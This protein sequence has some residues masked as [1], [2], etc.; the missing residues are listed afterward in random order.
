[1]RYAVAVHF[2]LRLGLASLVIL[3]AACERE[4]EREVVALVEQPLRVELVR[5]TTASVRLA[6][7]GGH[8]PLPLCAPETSEE[9]QLRLEIPERGINARAPCGA[10]AEGPPPQLSVDASRTRV[11]C[12]T[13]RGRWG[14]LYLGHDGR[15]FRHPRLEPEGEALDW[16]T[17]PAF[18][19]AAISIHEGY[20]FAWRGLLY[21]EVRASSGEAALV[22]LLI[23]VAGSE[24]AGFH[25]QRRRGG[26]W[27]VAA[28]GLSETGRVA[29]AAGL[30]QAVRAADEPSDRLR[31]RAER[32]AAASSPPREPS[33]P[34]GRVA[35]T[36]GDESD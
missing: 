14:I 15:A 25:Y 17:I 35:P 27:A 33:E 11:A 5:A 24:P 22:R 31:E 16:S 21:D 7:A 30:A 8:V 23:A 13:P 9:T 18:A 32:M 26:A 34:P 28:E 29:L 19:D 3:F 20:G 1:M 12:R 36:R 10:P 2:D 6:C 4:T